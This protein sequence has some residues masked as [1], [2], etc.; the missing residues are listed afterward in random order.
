LHKEAKDL[1][2]E[3]LN[4][5]KQKAQNGDLVHDIDESQE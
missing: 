4:Y 2:S 1:V 3:V 5:L